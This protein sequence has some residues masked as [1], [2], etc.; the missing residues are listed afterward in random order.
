MSNFNFS[1]LKLLDS[2]ERIELGGLVIN[3]VSRIVTLHDSRYELSK[4]QLG[5]FCYLAGKMRDSND[6]GATWD[7]IA[8]DLKIKESYDKLSDFF[9]SWDKKTKKNPAYGLVD[10]YKQ[11]GKTYYRLKTK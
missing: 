7:E 2:Q 3:R 11:G 5:I 8:N 6:S 10:P 9:R 4:K 1:S